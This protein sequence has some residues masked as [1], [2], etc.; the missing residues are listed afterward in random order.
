M[1]NLFA[2]ID[3]GSSA[4]RMDIAEVKDEGRLLVLDSL[5]R[6]V[7][8]GKDAFT[9]GGLSEETLR[10]ACSVLQ[11]YKKV[12]DTY[13]VTRYRAVATSAVRESANSDT[14]LDRVLVSTGL[15]VEII[16][17]SEEN[18][19]TLA[20]VSES[21][22][23]EPELQEG[24]TLLVEVGGGSAD[25]TL[26]SGT[27][28]LLSGTYPL[29]SIRMSARVD[30]SVGTQEQRTRILRRQIGGLVKNVRRNIS[31]KEATNFVAIGGDVRFVA[32][33]T[34]NGVDDQ[35]C[36]I[37]KKQ[38]SDFVDAVSR[39][40]TDRLVE[41]Y[42]LPYVD[43]ET[44]LPAL[45]TYQLLLE[46]TQAI[47]VFISNANIRAGILRDL[48]P[49]EERD[50]LEKI[51]PQILSAARNLGKK[52]KYDEGH[53]MR[54]MQMAE[55]IFEELKNE[56]RMTD[57]HRLYL[58]VA[59]LL[60]DVGLFVSSRAHHKHSF[61]LIAHSDLFGLS[62]QELEVIANVARYHRRA[63]PQ[64]SH[65]PYVSLNRDD[66]MI[67]SK[68]AAILRVANVLDKEHVRPDDKIKI[69]REGDQLIITAPNLGDLT[70]GKAVLAN[71]GKFFSDVFGKKIV[72]REVSAL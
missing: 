68:L 58:Q 37:P 21:L 61:Y 36:V 20:A 32:K 43:A 71:A 56:Q 22:S 38:F 59:T 27:E 44:L 65:L 31:I 53:A 5:K 46:G 49:A 41:K 10:A 23:A 72:L 62:R 9:E 39:L 63:L 52:Y 18:R 64:R 28:P 8:L 45:L 40:S 50:R 6:G 1:E 54:V 26:L 12:M 55:M 67:V 17:G 25:V 4:I 16:D 7:Q 14:F 24:Q 66:R 34:G 3:I 30:S 57:S 47:S 13:G 69:S 35:A 42:S 70:L 29:G 19:L 60:H 2:A 51:T 33:A 15:D 11:D 48:I